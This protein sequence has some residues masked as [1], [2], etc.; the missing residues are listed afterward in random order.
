MIYSTKAVGDHLLDKLE[1]WMSRFEMP[2][3]SAY[4]VT[5]ADI[6]KLI[7]HASPGSMKTNPVK[8]TDEAIRLIQTRL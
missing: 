1:T 8:L 5:E 6:P 3:L 7:A 2:L 4:G